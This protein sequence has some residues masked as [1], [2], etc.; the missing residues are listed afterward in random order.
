LDNPA[1]ETL[2]HIADQLYGALNHISPD[3]L[4]AAPDCGM[5]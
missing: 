5:K 1:A 3:R 4:I 2:E